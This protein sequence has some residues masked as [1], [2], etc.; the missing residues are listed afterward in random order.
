MTD[1]LHPSAASKGECPGWA[2]AGERL[3]FELLLVCEAAGR[4]VRG[5]WPP[6][7]L[8]TAPQ[9]PPSPN[10][11][12]DGQR[13]GEGRSRAPAPGALA[14]TPP[15]CPALRPAA[16]GSW[17][18]AGAGCCTGGT[19]GPV[20]PQHLSSPCP[21]LCHT[22]KCHR[23]HGYLMGT[24]W[25]RLPLLLAVPEPGKEESWAE[26][27]GLHK[28]MGPRREP[29]QGW[30]HCGQPLPLPAPN[31]CS[32]PPYLKRGLQ[33]HP[34][35]G[36]CHRW[37]EVPYCNRKGDW[38]KG[39][40]WG[41]ILPLPPSHSTSGFHQD[42]AGGPGGPFGSRAVLLSSRAQPLCPHCSPL[43]L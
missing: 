27:L 9:L 23:I 11:M 30:Q 10:W 4:C 34:A 14:R 42:R 3:T 32:L 7:P 12:T 33:P 2:G 20:R 37:Q 16:A 17:G 36:G 38:G 5:R 21:S 19:L 1:A 8:P 28:D 13:Q 25:P 41:R 43:S 24:E 22:K 29:G 26:L 35:C 18:R 39:S 15:G 6:A 40:R 31:G